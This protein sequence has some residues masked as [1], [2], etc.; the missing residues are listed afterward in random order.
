MVFVD[1]NDLL[2]ITFQIGNNSI[3][4]I[5][6]DTCFLNEM[7]RVI[8]IFPLSG[9]VWRM[10]DFNGTFNL[11]RTRFLLVYFVFRRVCDYVGSV[12]KIKKNDC[13]VCLNR[14]QSRR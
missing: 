3:E 6:R 12:S 1:V 13:F 8:R 9:F 2:N 11:S 4:T 14:H 10:H 7:G 5:I